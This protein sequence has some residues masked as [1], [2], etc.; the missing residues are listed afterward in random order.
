M[1]AR[2]RQVCWPVVSAGV[3]ALSIVHM[4][5]C[6]EDTSGVERKRQA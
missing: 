1:V 6:K 5:K 4:S 2:K 3:R